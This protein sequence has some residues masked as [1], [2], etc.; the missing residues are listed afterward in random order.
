L[1]EDEVVGMSH[2][3]PDAPVRIFIRLMK[4]TIFFPVGVAIQGLSRHLYPQVDGNNWVDITTLPLAL[5][6]LPKEFHGYRLVQISDFHLGTW[7]T[8]SH[9]AEA[10]DLINQLEPDAVAITGDLVTYAPERFAHD[11]VEELSRLAPRDASL[12]VLGNHDHWTD[13]KLLRQI[14]KEA[15]IIDLSNDVYTLERGA[16][17][18]SF[19]GVDD[20]YDGLDRLDQVLERLPGEDAAILL[21]HEPDFADISAETGRFDLQISGHTHGGQLNLPLV[22]LPYLPRYGRKYPSG[23]YLVNGMVQYTNRGLGTAE[24]Q[25]RYN[26]SPEITLFILQSKGAPLPPS[27]GSHAAA[28]RNQDQ[29]TDRLAASQNK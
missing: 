18:L 7:L 27:N 22:G 15:G 16:A 23:L 5:P 14:L 3:K 10:V 2:R 24:M 20:F 4:S 12:A 13:P 1:D 19:A 28:H 17:R 29:N 25:I 11:L 9:L 21:A 8:R 26:C 6:R